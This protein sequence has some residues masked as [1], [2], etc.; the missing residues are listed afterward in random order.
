MFFRK[1]LGS[2]HPS[3]LEVLHPAQVGPE[4]NVDATGYYLRRTDQGVPTQLVAPNFSTD[5]NAI[6]VTYNLY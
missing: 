3:G 4:V 1:L 2:E 6:P 5:L